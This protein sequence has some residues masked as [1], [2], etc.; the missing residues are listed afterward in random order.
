MMH[1]TRPPPVNVE[2]NHDTGVRDRA[3][4]DRGDGEMSTTPLAV[5]GIALSLDRPR[6]MG[7][8]N[9]TPDSFSD[10]GQHPTTDARV[11]LATELVEGGADVIDVGGQ[12][13]ITSVP[14]VDPDTEIDRVAPVIEAVRARHP[15]V[16][17]SIDTYKPAVAD[18]ALAAG[19]AI[20]N[21][22]SGLLHPELAD[23]AAAHHA[24]LV[25]MHNRSKPKVRMTDPH[26]YVDVVGDV[27]TFLAEKT[28]EAVRRGVPI[29]AIILDPGPDFAKTPHQ[30]VE[31]LRRLD[32]VNPDGRPLLLAISRKDFIGALTSTAPGDRGDGTLAALAFLAASG[33]IFRVHDV[34]GA[35]RFLRVLAAL[36]GET[37]VP[38][39]LLL[40]PHLRRTEASVAAS[41]SAPSV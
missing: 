29:E 27:R 11:A 1:G 40:A 21:D 39:D 18:A 34:L 9:A 24:A 38:E 10:A 4:N 8:V 26:A 7:V 14:E 6:L 13:G 23:V 17:I 31:V 16:P 19:A 28:A 20:V 36:R 3:E 35:A 33:R 37:E 25:V 5:G 41:R 15:D 12:S 30:T 32:E 22:T 2:R